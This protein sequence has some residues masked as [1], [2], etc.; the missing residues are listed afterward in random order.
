MKQLNKNVENIIEESKYQLRIE[1]A[2]KCLQEKASFDFVEKVCSFTKREV[3]AIFNALNEQKVRKFKNVATKEDEIS[4]NLEKSNELKE[5]LKRI[6]RQMIVETKEEKRRSVELDRK[7]TAENA[8]LLMQRVKEEKRNE[9]LRKKIEQKQEM[10]RKKQLEKIQ[11]AEK[12]PKESLE[13]LNTLNAEQKMIAS[14]GNCYLN[15][16]SVQ[17]AVLFSKVSKEEVTRIYN[18]F[19]NK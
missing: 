11:A 3:M 17:Q 7:I 8:R 1:I 16:L 4:K 9:I 15:G 10:Q 5:E 19:K 14:V 6:Q 12:L 18:S 2:E 13:D